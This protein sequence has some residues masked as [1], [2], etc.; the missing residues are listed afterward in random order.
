MSGV[1]EPKQVLC[2]YFSRGK[3]TKGDTCRFSHDRATSRRIT[4]CKYFKA[5]HCEYGSK[6]KYDHVRIKE[7]ARMSAR[8][9]KSSATTTQPKKLAWGRGAPAAQTKQPSAASA[10]P[11][12]AQIIQAQKQPTQ[13]QQKKSQRGQAQQAKTLASTTAAAK[14]SSTSAWVKP[15]TAGMSSGQKGMQVLK[16]KPVIK[17]E[18]VNA[19]EFVPTPK[20][21]SAVAKTN[22][23]HEDPAY[24]LCANGLTYG[25]CLIEDCPFLHGDACPACGMLCMHPDKPEQ[26]ERH[27]MSCISY[28]D[29][30]YEKAMLAKRSAGIECGIC[31]DVI[32]E[33]EGLSSQ[34]FGILPNCSH[35]FCLDCIRDWRR[36]HEQQGDIVRS[37]P[38]CRT[39]SHFVVPST[40]WVEDPVEKVELV[41]RFK[42]KTSQ[43]DCM[44]FDF[45]KGVCPFGSSCFYKHAL[46]DGTISTE[47]TRSVIG[48]DG[49][50]RYIEPN[51]LSSFF[52]QRESDAV[53]AAYDDSEQQWD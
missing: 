10:K 23:I 50:R 26:N 37:C 41:E 34:R 22:T 45:G 14:A 5:G 17:D 35:A 49:E 24:I 31:L 20:L 9:S 39:V 13:K 40:Y 51:L 47:M 25:S 32:V 8:S 15:T 30:E 6:C 53:T 42:S 16:M 18:W 29:K 52:D 33:K 3:C 4:L 19:P 28:A 1:L 2:E 7:P 44:N 27:L 36:K 48:Q 38:L 11:T 21:Y 46:P 43:I 12:L